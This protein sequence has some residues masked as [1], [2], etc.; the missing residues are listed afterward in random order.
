[1]VEGREATHESL[2][3]L[4]IA[5]PVYFSDGRVLVRVCLNVRLGDDVP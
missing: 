3:V 1:M 2:D 5:D 4:D